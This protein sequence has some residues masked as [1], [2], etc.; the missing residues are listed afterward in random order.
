MGD[1]NHHSR[2]AREKREAALDEFVKRRFTVVG[3]LVLKAV[4]QAIEAVAAALAGEHFHVN[5]RTA[6]AQRVR[7]VKQNFPEVGADIDVVWGVYGDLG[8]N[9]LDGNRAKDAVEAMERILNAI[10][11]RT[12]IRFR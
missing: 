12:G 10:E 9:G 1:A 5:S 8:Y 11:K 2:I 7:W 3:D 6:H 4:E